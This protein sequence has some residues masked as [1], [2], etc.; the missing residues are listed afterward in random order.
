MK[1]LRERR[2][3]DQDGWVEQ[4]E[5]SRKFE[6]QWAKEKVERKAQE[7]HLE[8]YVDNWWTE[9]HAEQLEE[10]KR[11]NQ[12]ELESQELLS[13]GSEGRLL[14]HP[15]EVSIT[16]TGGQQSSLVEEFTLSERACGDDPSTT[17]ETTRNEGVRHQKDSILLEGG[18][19]KEYGSEGHLL[20]HPDQ[21]L[22]TLTGGR[23]SSSQEVFAGP[24]RASGDGPSVSS[25]ES[26]RVMTFPDGSPITPW[27]GK[28]WRTVEDRI[29]LRHKAERQAFKR[30][31]R[32]I[33]RGIHV[34]PPNTSPLSPGGG[35]PEKGMKDWL[36]IR[37]DRWKEEVK[38]IVETFMW[39]KK[40]QS[41]MF[42]ERPAARERLCRHLEIPYIRYPSRDEP[43]ESIKDMPENQEAIR[44]M[45]ELNPVLREKEWA[46][47]VQDWQ[48]PEGVSDGERKGDC[49][50]RRNR[51]ES[52]NFRHRLLNRVRG[53]YRHRL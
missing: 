30:R 25:Q 10:L 43:Y 7:K 32:E 40:R 48:D 50:G 16:L 9:Y 6:E 45:S 18:E 39:W 17:I 53:S 49:D 46:R 31:G 52:L 47:K 1:R 44:E 5:R 26:G 27:R 4:S 13:C 28:T 8:E 3:A 34:E 15:D 36:R 24:E 22:I 19:T 12:E 35:S 51:D 2:L 20:E 29:A 42:F 41:E 37:G 14:E 21:A 23:F 38:R 33:N 11:K